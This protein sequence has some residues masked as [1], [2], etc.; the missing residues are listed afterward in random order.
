[1][2]TYRLADALPLGVIQQNRETPGTDA[3]MRR[4]LEEYL[5]AGHGT[6]VLRR[7]EVATLVVDNWQRFD[8]VRYHLHAWVVMPNHVH[9]V[10]AI[11]PRASLSRIVHSWK[12]YTATVIN[13]CLRRTGR[14]WQEDYWDRLIRDE[15]HFISAVD[16]I[17]GNPAKA[18]L[19]ERAEDWPW[20]SARKWLG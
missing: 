8:G 18:G 13:R 6:C 3:H 15:K 14:L 12:S 1:M 20:S 2:I 4:R 5:D 17:H 10:I 19:V 16:Y 9:V 11:K 7:P